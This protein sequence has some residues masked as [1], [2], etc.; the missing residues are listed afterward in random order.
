QASIVLK[1]NGVD[2]VIVQNNTQLKIL[3]LNDFL[4]NNKR[5]LQ[6]VNTD[7]KAV[8]FAVI[9]VA[10]NGWLNTFLITIPLT[11]FVRSITPSTA[12]AVMTSNTEDC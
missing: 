12:A 2:I 1:T 3:S 10:S 4:W 8:Y 7:T 11:K 6:Q 9:G 5:F